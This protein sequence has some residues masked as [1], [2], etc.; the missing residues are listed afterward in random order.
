MVHGALVCMTLGVVGCIFGGNN[1]S[2]SESRSY[3]Y[4]ENTSIK[5]TIQVWDFAWLAAPDTIP[6]VKFY[7]SDSLTF[8]HTYDIKHSEDGIV[9]EDYFLSLHFAVPAVP[10]TFLIDALNPEKV[11]LS[12]TIE[13]TN[14]YKPVLEAS[15]SGWKTGTGS[16]YATGR[17]IYSLATDP[18]S[19]NIAGRDTIS[20]QGIFKP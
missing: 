13:G 5:D 17:A 16:W 3:S 4:E 18:D 10:D 6:W 7:A 9:L 20:F 15:I 2:L 1:N 11:R 14:G 12:R 19:V 8:T